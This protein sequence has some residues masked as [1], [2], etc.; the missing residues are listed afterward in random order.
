MVPALSEKLLRR[1]EQKA[2]YVLVGDTV[3]GGNQFMGN[4]D[5][6]ANFHPDLWYPFQLKSCIYI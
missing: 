2:S 1:P 3:L 5:V 4:V 6:F